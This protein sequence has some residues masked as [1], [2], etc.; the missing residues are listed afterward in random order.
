LSLDASAAKV[1]VLGAGPGGLTLARLLQRRGFDVKVYE[2]DAD[3]SARSQGGTLDLDAESGQRAIREMRLETEFAAFSRPEGQALRILNKQ[4][5]MLWDEK[6]E[7]G[8]GSRPEIDRGVLRDLLLDSLLP[9][10]VLWDAHVTEI[11]PLPNEQWQVITQDDRRCVYDL[12]VGCDG[13]SSRARPLLSSA[14]PVYSGITY[15]EMGIPN[16]DQT[17]PEAAAL[18]GHGSVFALDDAKA[19]IAQ[20]N[21]GGYIRLYAALA[22]EGDWAKANAVR[23][24]SP[25]SARAASLSLF[26]DWSPGLR[27]L[28]EVAEDRFV[29]R[30]LSRLPFEHRWQTRP[31]LTLLGDAAHLM[32]PF[33]GQGAN[34]AMLDAVDLADCLCA[35]SSM[36]DALAAFETAMQGRAQDAAQETQRNQEMFFGGEAAEN[37]ARQM[38]SFMAEASR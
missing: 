34:L 18:V 7:D 38:A 5:E 22:V 2:R 30:P 35:G 26:A 9:E 19:I 25:A 37:V 11:A 28:L 32:T 15:V 4:G 13:A 12:V 6:A 33:A 29:L 8:G 27:H 1:A 17:A 20:R 3:R 16:A 36:T 23:F 21:G 31:G 24:Q 14:T 10:T